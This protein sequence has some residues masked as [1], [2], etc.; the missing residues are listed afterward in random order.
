MEKTKDLEL[1]G[2]L[3]A[4]FEEKVQ[5]VESIRK[6]LDQ[7]RIF[8]SRLE[9]RFGGDD[10]LSGDLSNLA[11]TSLCD[12]HIGLLEQIEL[13]ELNDLERVKYLIEG[14]SSIVGWEIDDYDGIRAQVEKSGQMCESCC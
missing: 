8:Q 5:R 6:D 9:Y 2:D 10:S 4:L 3:L 1:L 12:L 11:E 7:A 14:S 13:A